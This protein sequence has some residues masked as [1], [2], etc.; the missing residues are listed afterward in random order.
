M[1]HSE[2]LLGSNFVRNKIAHVNKHAGAAVKAALV[3]PCLETLSMPRK[4]HR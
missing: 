4:T 3:F 2:A 1:K